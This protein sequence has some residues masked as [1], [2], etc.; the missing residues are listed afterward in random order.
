MQSYCADSASNTPLHGFDFSAESVDAD[1]N[2]SLDT[3][4]C[5]VDCTDEQQ[6]PP[7]EEQA[8][9]KCPPGEEQAREQC[10]LGKEETREQCPPGKEQAR[11]QCPPGEEQAREQCPPG[12]ELAHEHGETKEKSQ[13]D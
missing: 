4:V 1:A 2:C 9:E 12:E 8:H 13:T 3:H 7:G 6:C 11:E 10:P 5:E